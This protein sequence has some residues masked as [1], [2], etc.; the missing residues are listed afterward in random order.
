[1][2]SRISAAMLLG[3]IAAGCVFAQ[4]P[5]PAAQLAEQRF[6][7]VQL[8]KGVSVQEF[9]ETMGFISAATNMTCTVCHGEASAGNWDRYADDPPLKRKARNMMRMVDGINKA[10]FGGV[11]RVTCYTCHRNAAVPKVTPTL[12]EQYA[13]PLPE[14]PDDIFGQAPGAPTPDAVLDKYLQAIGGQA[15][16]AALTSFIGKGKY[17][18]YDDPDSSP[19]EIYAKAPGQFAQYNHSGAGDRMTVDDGRSAWIAQAESEVPV[20]VVTLAGGDLQGVHLEA[21]LF[22]PGRIK[23]MFTDLH[24]GFPLAGALSILPDRTGSGIDERELVVMQGKTAVGGVK[25]KLYFE[26]ESGLLVRMVRFTNLPYGFITTEMDYA[27]YRD[28]GGFKIPHRI[29]KTWVDGRSIVTLDSVQ[30]NVPVDATKF[31]KPAAP[32]EPAGA[33]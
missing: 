25:V 6:K 24:V 26:K 4:A 30:V 28:V 33:K 21:Q 3:G 1:M 27:D 16:A 15:K 19:V 29:T 9:M 17:E 32:K 22:F 12:A 5:G 18:G 14:D 20:P 23:Q 8:L 7:N 2:H 10:N 31:N 13:T 11:R